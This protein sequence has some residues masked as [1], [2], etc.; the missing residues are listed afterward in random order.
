MTA[1]IGASCGYVCLPRSVTYAQYAPSRFSQLLPQSAPI[2]AVK[3]V[4]TKA[5]VRA[6]ALWRKFITII[7]VE[8]S[9]RLCRRSFFLGTFLAQSVPI[10]AV[11]RVITKAVVHVRAS[12]CNSVRARL[13]NFPFSNNRISAF[14]RLA[15]ARYRR[16]ADPLFVFC[17]RT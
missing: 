15:A 17:G 6:C 3:R 5:V 1:H 12:R 16:F 10:C 4:I 14:P 13:G 11:K 2:C 9:I 7:V 8:I